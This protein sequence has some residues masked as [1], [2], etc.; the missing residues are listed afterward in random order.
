MADRDILV[1]RCHFGRSGK[2]GQKQDPSGTSHK[3]K[4]RI[5]SNSD[6]LTELK[7]NENENR[8]SRA[9][10]RKM[11][12]S[13][14]R[15]DPPS[16]RDP[17]VSEEEYIENRRQRIK[18]NEEK[19]KAKKYSTIRFSEELEIFTKHS[20]KHNDDTPKKSILRSNIDRNKVSSTPPKRRKDSLLEKIQRLSENDAE[21]S[22]H[23]KISDPT[24]PVPARQDWNIAS[25]FPSSTENTKKMLTGPQRQNSQNERCNSNEYPCSIENPQKTSTGSIRSGQ[26]NPQTRD[27]QNDQYNSSEY[28]VKK[29]AGNISNSPLA[30]KDGLKNKYDGYLDKKY[31]SNES[32]ITA[33]EDKL[34]NKYDGYLD[35]KYAGKAKKPLA[36]KDGVVSKKDTKLGVMNDTPRTKDDYETKNG[37]NPTNKDAGNVHS[38]TEKLVGFENKYEP[39][40]FSP[41]LCSVDTNITIPNTPKTT[42]GAESRPQKPKSKINGNP[43]T[44]GKFVRKR[45]LRKLSYLH[46]NERKT[47]EEN[48]SSSFLQSYADDS[49]FQKSLTKDTEEQAKS[50]IRRISIYS[51]DSSTTTTTSAA[52]RQDEKSNSETCV[53]NSGTNLNLNRFDWDNDDF[54]DKPIHKRIDWVCF[55]DRSFARDFQNDGL[56]ISQDEDFQISED[57]DFKIPPAKLPKKRCETWV[58]WGVIGMIFT[59]FVFSFSIYFLIVDETEISDS[60]LGEHFGMEKC[61]MHDHSAGTRLSS[62]YN[63]TRQHLLFQSIENMSAMDK[64]GTPQRKALCWISDYDAYTSDVSDDGNKEEILQRYSLAVIYF[65]SVDTEEKSNDTPSSL[66][67]SDFL[68]ADHE[69]DWEAVICNPHG[70]VSSLRLFN[71]SLSGNLPS[72]IGNLIALNFIDFTNSERHRKPIKL[73]IIAARQ[74]FLE[75]H[76]SS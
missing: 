65:S 56:Q 44:R 26:D 14:V 57:E 9:A 58:I 32:S 66:R 15:K 52:E 29:Y 39:L 8:I 33:N 30:N 4:A 61:I 41:F 36:T 64:S 45:D 16:S 63:A 27:S 20:P 1:D 42:K 40:N 49:F 43:M 62:R 5:F 17:P 34:K 72:E 7:S 31:T 75:W 38:H 48:P 47:S 73:G 67:Y 74:K 11:A 51:P 59:C 25:L 22:D 55:K 70:K 68:S 3:G 50:L 53:T 71:N 18:Q 35:K 60:P 28:L 37:T 24:Q 6:I 69:C 23:S 2:S 46:M 54:E 19:H 13:I 21:K 76:D 12:K 10:R